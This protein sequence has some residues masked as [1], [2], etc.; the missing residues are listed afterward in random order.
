MGV[1]GLSPRRMRRRGGYF[2]TP[3]NRGFAFFVRGRSLK[4]FQNPA[5]C[6]ENIRESAE[7]RGA[8]VSFALNSEE[9]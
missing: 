5:R 1:H 4:K 8:Q 2:S 6:E 3:R 7:N 9:E